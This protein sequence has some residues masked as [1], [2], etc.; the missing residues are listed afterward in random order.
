MGSRVFR[1]AASGTILLSAL[2]T[3]SA[4]TAQ[5][6]PSMPSTLRYGSGLLGIPV[7]SVLD[8]LELQGTYS[9]FFVSTGRSAQVDAN[10]VTTV[11]IGNW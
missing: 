8:H 9:G 10:G 5:Q 4:A 6:T 11:D 7:S 1:A 2:L 3:A